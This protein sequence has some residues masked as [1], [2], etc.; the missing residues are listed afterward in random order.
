VGN[1]N[2]PGWTLQGSN[3]CGW[4]DNNWNGSDIYRNIDLSA[5]PHTKV[6][7]KTR[8]YAN[9]SF[10]NEYTQIYVN[11]VS[12]WQQYRP[13]AY[14]CAGG[15]TQFWDGI[16]PGWSTNVWCYADADVTVPHSSTNLKLGY[17][18]NLNEGYSNENWAYDQVEVW[19]AV[20]A[21]NKTRYMTMDT[22]QT[23]SMST[24]DA[25]L[26]LNLENKSNVNLSFY[27]KEYNDT[28]ETDDGVYFSD[29]AGA[30]F[31]KV[32]S[33]QGG[34]A[35][36]WYA[37]NLNLSAL[38]EADADLDMTST[39]IIK[40]V[41][42]DAE[43][44][45]NDGFAFDDI[46]VWEASY[47]TLPYTQTFESA[48][49][50]EWAF[51]A[52]NYG[53]VKVNTNYTPYAGSKHLTMDTWKDNSAGQNEAKLFVNL[54][55][56]TNKA[57]LT[58]YWKEFNDE[59]NTQDGVFLS[60]D[61]GATWTKIMNLTG[62]DN[63]WKKYLLYLSTLADAAGLTLSDTSIIKF[64]Q[65]GDRTI[66]N[67]GFAFDNIQVSDWTFYNQDFSGAS[68]PTG[69]TTGGDTT[70]AVSTSGAYNDGQS[71]RTS[72]MDSTT[73]GTTWAKVTVDVPLN[74]TVTF[75]FKRYTTSSV[76]EVDLFFYVNGVYVG[77]VGGSGTQSWAEKTFTYDNGATASQLELKWE[78]FK[79]ADRTGYGI[80]DDVKVQW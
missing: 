52:T 66:S 46:K 73:N 76:Y 59:P 18:G 33:L 13:D 19:A 50:N 24:N 69:W 74:T 53:Q 57:V 12:V 40:F 4:F 70:W 15:Y 79:Y 44:I 56:L 38:V 48:L 49:G 20:P 62:N 10:D 11:D 27:W 80:I 77:S 36:T 17:R 9:L 45:S 58:F 32:H 16:G 23:S 51:A 8:M 61:A 63:T 43:P 28:D 42:K 31:K 14:S 68:M 55:D 67:D 65:Y 25:M 41:Q 71:L 3:V 22:F 37:V 39:F 78:F 26:H 64:Q 5:Y 54:A 72:N 75:K 47:A 7:V 21:G 60:V 6:R 29:D 34:T 35:G 30:T 1:I 2:W